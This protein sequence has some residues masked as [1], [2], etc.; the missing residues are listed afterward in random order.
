VDEDLWELPDKERGSSATSQLQSIITAEGGEVNLAKIIGKAYRRELII[1]G[2][3]KAVTVIIS[4]L[5]PILLNRILR[6]LSERWGDKVPRPPTSVG[7]GWAIALL[8]MPVIF[9]ITENQYFLLGMRSGMKIRSALQG[10]IYDK[11]LTMSPS[12][13]AGSSLGEIVNLMQLDTQRISD[14]AQTFHII[15]SA[16]LQLI[17]TCILLFYFIRW[18][19][20]IGIIVTLLT[21]PIQGKIM[22]ILTR[23]RKAAVGI[24]DQRV[25]LVNEILQGIK[26][27]KFYAW[28]APFSRKIEEKRDEEIVNFGKTI[29]ATSIFFSL[30]ISIPV[31]IA[32]VTF[33]FYVGVFKNLL[34]PA[35]IFTAITYLNNLRGPLLMI[36]RVVQYVDFAHTLIYS[37]YLTHFC[38][39]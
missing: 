4:V 7:L 26:A 9:A 16:P 6:F 29:W 5:N 10:I 28:E 33:S 32:V 20:L 1:S 30:F 3:L 15:W 25:K 38:N 11:S 23:L 36:P 13:R 31:V 37:K 19:A 14:F 12:A 27:V 34:D 18:S 39:L 2:I 17:V 35:T 22:A 21:I 24:T 8:I